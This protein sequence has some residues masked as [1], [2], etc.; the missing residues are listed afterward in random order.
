MK[1]NYMAPDMLVCKLKTNTHLCE[2]SV[3]NV[4]G[5]AGITKGGSRSD[6]EGDARGFDWD[7]DDY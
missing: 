3:G 7:D 2:A 4:Y 1:K 5:D 6:V